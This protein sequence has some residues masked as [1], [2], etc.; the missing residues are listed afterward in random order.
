MSFSGLLSPTVYV[1]DVEP[2]LAGSYAI[3]AQAPINVGID[4]T[5]A[6]IGTS[7]AQGAISFSS[8]RVATSC[9]VN[10]TLGGEIYITGISDNTTI[11]ISSESFTGQGYATVTSAVNFQFMLNSLAIPC[12]LDLQ[13]SLSESG[14]A[15][16]SPVGANGTADVSVHGTI[17]SIIPVNTS[18]QAPFSY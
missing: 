8:C 15:S 18:Y 11:Q 14:T 10:V 16:I 5:S 2:C 17:C 4:F 7:N 3:E 9:G 13:T 12:P 6:D 1:S